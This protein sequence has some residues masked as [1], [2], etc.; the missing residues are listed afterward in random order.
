LEARRSVVRLR[1]ILAAA[2]FGVLALALLAPAAGA[3]VISPRAA[4]SPNA[5]D[6]R[7]AYWV[8]LVVAAVIVIAVHAALIAAVVRFRSTRGNEPARLSAGR[9]FFLRAAVPLAALA[10]AL[11]VF[12]VVITVRSQ[13]V[14]PSGPDGLTASAAQT[15]QVGVRGV[16]S[17]VLHDAV[18][19]LRNTQPSIPTG[20]PVK[21]G[22]LV[23]DAVAQQWIWRFFYPGGPG[24]VGQSGIPAYDPNGG[25]PGDR[26]YSVD[27]LVVPVDTSVLLNITSTDVIHR[28]FTPALGGQ[29]DAIPGHVSQTWF[30]ADQTGVYPGQSTAF[31]GA[32]YSAM[33]SWVRVVTPDEYQ[34]YLSDQTRSLAEAQAFV[35]QAIDSGN[36]PGATP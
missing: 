4:H 17:Q 27:E 8:T 13:K 30:R 14:E 18:D 23:I 31:S 32:G 9:G 22:P 6:I 24:K 16:S 28:W 34:Q 1:A 26:T 3:S 15:A 11:F 19:T 21:G 29:V 7:T 20:A 2:G 5:D 36:V 10:L 25:R 33:R 35:Q 12:G